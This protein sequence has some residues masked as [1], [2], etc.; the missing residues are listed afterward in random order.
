MAARFKSLCFLKS[1]SS[2]NISTNKLGVKIVE[3]IS[4]LIKNEYH[5]NLPFSP[6]YTTFHNL[7][8]RSVLTQK[9]KKRSFFPK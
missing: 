9:K 5:H 2:K 1:I 3:G 7:L 6:I 8:A 4:S